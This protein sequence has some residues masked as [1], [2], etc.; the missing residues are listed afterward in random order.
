MK[1]HIL[2][3]ARKIIIT[4]ALIDYMEQYYEEKGG[5]N[6][7]LYL[8]NEH[9][10]DY[11]EW[12]YDDLIISSAERDLLLHSDE[13]DLNEGIKTEAAKSFSCITHS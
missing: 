13:C 1:T 12:A 11:V 9:F 8:V 2:N 3:R 5:E 4:E 10:D 7:I 6:D